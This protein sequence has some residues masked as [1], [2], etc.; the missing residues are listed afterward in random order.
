MLINQLEIPYIINYFDGHLAIKT[1]L[2]SLID[3][4]KSE[5]LTNKDDYYQDNISRLDWDKKDDWNREWVQK[6]LPLLHKNVDKM[7]NEIGFENHNV[8]CLWFQQY[9]KN[10]THGWHVHG[11]NYTGVYY[12]ELPEGTPTTEYCQPMNT[13]KIGKFNVK[14]GD[15][16]LFPSFVIHRAIKN[17]SDKRKTIISFNINLG[18]PL[19]GYEND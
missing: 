11:D 7:M 13:K 17:L 8:L 1:D 15:I 10:G 9:L 3:N 6:F 4:A 14:E 5:S 18:R 19:R 12:L 16:L 2:L